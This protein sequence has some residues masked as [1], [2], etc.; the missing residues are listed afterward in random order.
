MARRFYTIL[1]IPDVSGKLRRITIPSLWFRAIMAVSVSLV[2]VAGYL[3][4]GYFQMGLKVEEFENLRKETR[5]QR[6][7][8]R[9]FAKNLQMFEGQMVRLQ[10]LD[11]KLRVMTALGMPEKGNENQTLGVGGQEGK[12]EIDGLLGDLDKNQSEILKRVQVRLRDLRREAVRQEVSF[13]QID[14]FIHGQKNL[15]AFT[16]SIWPTRGF[17]SS[18]FGYRISPFT[19]KR[20]MHEGI[21][22]S[23]R[24]G[25][26]I[27]APAAGVV[28]RQGRDVSLGKMI[29]ID[30]GHGITTLYAHT[31]RD[32]VKVGQKVKRG[33]LIATVGS[34]GRATG[35]HLHYEVHVNGVPVNPMRYIVE[36]SRSKR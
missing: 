5:E 9:V 23:T 29:E 25:S 11:K 21:D 19:G 28:I 20:E 6:A 17:I 12:E 14:E 24:E 36:E 7:Q 10:R 22:I 33:D 13:Q 1:V 8:I 32:F 34:T 26:P 27:V 3:T 18:G 35:P 2:L 30:H 15:L 4:Y 31:S 16:P